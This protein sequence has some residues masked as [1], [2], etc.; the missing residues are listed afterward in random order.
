[1]RTNVAANTRFCS[2]LGWDAGLR[3]AGL[4]RGVRFA[5]NSLISLTRT[6][7]NQKEKHLQPGKA[8]VIGGDDP[9]RL[10]RGVPAPGAKSNGATVVDQHDI[11]DN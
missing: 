10:S 5:T 3:A 2:A 6:S 11:A 9:P 4:R 1:M 7:R 8:S